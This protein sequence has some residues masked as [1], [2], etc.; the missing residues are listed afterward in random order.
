MSR[1]DDADPR[2]EAVARRMARIQGHHPEAI[3]L[4]IYRS[5]AAYVLEAVDD[6]AC[7]VSSTEQQIAQ[8][9]AE[10]DAARADAALCLKE[11]DAIVKHFIP[12]GKFRRAQ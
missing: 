4:V 11:R 2:I 1:P 10:R 6:P 8:L 3:D 7:E 5:M 12:G 9:M